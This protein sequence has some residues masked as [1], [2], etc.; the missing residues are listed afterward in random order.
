MI[1]CNKINVK[2]SDSQLKKLWFDAKS[3]IGAILRMNIKIFNAN[4]LPYEL[5]LKKYRKQS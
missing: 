3:Q 2:L 5:L 4:N 1:E